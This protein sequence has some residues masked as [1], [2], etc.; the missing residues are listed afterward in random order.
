MIERDVSNRLLPE[1]DAITAPFWEAASNG[2]LVLQYCTRCS[3]FWH[4]PVELCAVCRRADLLDWREVSG[5][6]TVY[7][8]INVHVSRIPGFQDRVPYVVLCVELDE[9]SGLRMFG[10]VAG[11]PE[12]VC[13]GSRVQVEFERVGGMTFPQFAIVTA[14]GNQDVGATA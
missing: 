8:Y 1:P 6:G 10:N 7:S 2:R 13:V 11:D 12:M 9:Q 14:D 3:R 4:F 5:R